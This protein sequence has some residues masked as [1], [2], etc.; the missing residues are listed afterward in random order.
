MTDESIIDPKENEY[1][2]SCRVGNVR[3]NRWTDELRHPKSHQHCDICFD[4]DFGSRCGSVGGYGDAVDIMRHMV[5]LE[6][7]RNKRMER[8]S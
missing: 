4:T 6:H 1:C 8:E 2:C 5:Q 7:L 3:L